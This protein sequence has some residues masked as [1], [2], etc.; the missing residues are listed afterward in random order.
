MQKAKSHLCSTN[1]VLHTSIFQTDGSNASAGD[2]MLATLFLPL[3]H[4][5]QEQ[6]HLLEQQ[7]YNIPRTKIVDNCSIA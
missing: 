7:E 2:P 3:T 4:F 1:I 6:G 5:C